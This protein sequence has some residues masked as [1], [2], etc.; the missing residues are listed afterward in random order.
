MRRRSSGSRVYLGHCEA[1]G[2]AAK[3]LATALRDEHGL[4]VWLAD[5]EVGLGEVIVAKHDEAIA[6]AEVALLVFSRKGLG[7]Q[8]MLQ[9]YAAMLT[10]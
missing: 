8:W 4:E 5:W 9:Q 7:D 3:G 2:A 10:Q 1:D 6:R